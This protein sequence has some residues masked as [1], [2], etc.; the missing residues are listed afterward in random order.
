MTS[1]YP[2]PTYKCKHFCQIRFSFLYTYTWRT[3]DKTEGFLP[4]WISACLLASS[5]SLLKLLCISLIRAAIY[6]LYTHRAL[7][8]FM[9]YNY[10]VIF[11][12]L[13]IYSKILFSKLRHKE[14]VQLSFKHILIYF[15]HTWNADRE[16]SNCCFTVQVPTMS[17][18]GL[19]EAESWQFN[20]GPQQGSKHLS[21]H[22]LIRMHIRKTLAQK[23]RSQV[24][25]QALHYRMLVS[26]VVT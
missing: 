7:A 17:G 9:L 14:L 19:P 1:M 3:A 11:V 4:I 15:H 5:T 23:W 26:Q 24:W 10:Y 22:Q 16:V 18:S 13:L 25:S 21:H 12:I 8:C 2:P 20:L 6:L